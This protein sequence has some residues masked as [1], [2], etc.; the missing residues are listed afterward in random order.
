MEKITREETVLAGNY[1][2]YQ[3]RLKGLEE[4]FETAQKRVESAVL[5]E[6]IGLALRKQRLDL[7]SAD[8]YFAGSEVRQIKMSEISEKQ[9]KLDQSLREL[10][11]P[12]AHADRVIDSVSFLSDVDRTSLD[13]KI[14]ELVT[15][16]LDI[17]HKLQSGNDRIFKLIQDIEFTEQQLVNTA[18]DFGE[19]LDRHLLWIRSSKP[20]AIGDIQKLQVSL[21]WF[22]NPANWGQLFNDLGRS[23]HQKTAIWI[24][25]L[26]IGLF[27]IVSRRWAR[28]KLKDIAE[29]VEQQVED[30]S[31]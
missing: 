22:F 3:S 28:R 13:L 21:G 27:L 24:I 7:P 11:D 15:N 12:K 19:L 16:R 10:S 6:A 17:I 26:L 23:F 1:E 14:Q 5:T 20:V 30:P 8:Q 18:E 2:K 29:C 31:C 9:I 4:E 25:G